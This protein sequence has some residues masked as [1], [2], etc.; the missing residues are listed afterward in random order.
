MSFLNQE[1]M[2]AFAVLFWLS[3][4]WL[5]AAPPPEKPAHLLEDLAHSNPV[6]ARRTLSLDLTLGPPREEVHPEP[7]IQQ[8]LGSAQ[9]E[10][11]MLWGLDVQTGRN[12]PVVFPLP[13][14]SHPPTLPPASYVRGWHIT[15][16]TSTPPIVMSTFPSSQGEESHR[17]ALYLPSL[18]GSVQQQTHNQAVQFFQHLAAVSPRTRLQYDPHWKMWKLPEMI[19]IMPSMW[20]DLLYEAWV[21]AYGQHRKWSDS[22]KT[23]LPQD[24]LGNMHVRTWFTQGSE[25]LKVRLQNPPPPPDWEGDEILV[26]RVKGKFLSAHDSHQEKVSIW[27]FSN[28]GMSLALVGVYHA[29]KSFFYATFYNLPDLKTFKVVNLRFTDGGTYLREVSQASV[30]FEKGSSSRT[31]DQ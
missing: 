4:V 31:P 12:H 22:V 11:S 24:K 16:G 7:V 26:R 25:V 6:S 9:G 3:A 30:S 18:D 8:H 10:D 14:F 23:E 2:V 20:F 17:S 29:P 5:C 15:P 13:A 19:V 28:N 21:E 1:M 27:R